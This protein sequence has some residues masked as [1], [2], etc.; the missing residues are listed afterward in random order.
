M[1]GP[2][3]GGTLQVPGS[4][5]APCVGSRPSG[6]LWSGLRP[7]GART[8]QWR[9]ERPPLLSHPSEKP[10]FLGLGVPC[11]H[12]IPSRIIPIHYGACCYGTPL[13]PGAGL[14]RPG[15][16]ASGLQVLQDD[17]WVKVRIRM[18]LPKCHWLGLLFAT[19]CVAG[20]APQEARGK[21]GACQ[22]LL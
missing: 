14:R 17:P 13:K 11:Q 15:A 4:V 21:E 9:E 1:A 8:K 12:L 20:G 10:L 19:V 22:C 2:R 7:T 3:A 5:P 18:L 6:S 16:S